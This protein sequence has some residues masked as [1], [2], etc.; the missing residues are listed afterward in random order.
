MLLSGEGVV[1]GEVC[2]F[3]N[4]EPVLNTLD[5]YEG[6][7]PDDARASLYLREVR[8]V[9]LS[10]TEHVSAWCYF[11]PSDREGSLLRDGARLIPS[12]I[13]SGNYLRTRT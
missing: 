11:M 2:F 7:Y 9:T 10:P 12:G 6:C 4:V 5:E 13:W 8:E 3:E 1:R